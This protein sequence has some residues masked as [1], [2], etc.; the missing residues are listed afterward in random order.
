MSRRSQKTDERP[1]ITYSTAEPSTRQ[2]ADRGETSL[3][4]GRRRTGEAVFPRQATGEFYTKSRGHRIERS[5]VTGQ[6]SIL[7]TAARRSGPRHHW[8][9]T[10]TFVTAARNIQPARRLAAS[11]V[12]PS[13]QDNQ[14]GLSSSDSDD[15]AQGDG[16]SN[17]NVSLETMG[18]PTE[19][20]YPGLR[21][22]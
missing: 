17:A 15:G 4:D 2:K 21:F 11:T 6:S 9:N 10:P 16:A 7:R 20:D 1:A 3:L 8:P 14:G 5:A 18:T 13:H 22:G 19:G 12:Q